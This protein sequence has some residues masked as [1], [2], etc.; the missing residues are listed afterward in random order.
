MYM[1]KL[2]YDTDKTK[3]QIPKHREQTCLCQGAMG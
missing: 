1:W 3:K 2:K